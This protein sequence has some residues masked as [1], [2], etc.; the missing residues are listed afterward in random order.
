MPHR[1]G[2][3]SENRNPAHWHW[4]QSSSAPDHGSGRWSCVKS[5][6]AI[7]D[8]TVSSCA[9]NATEVGKTEPGIVLQPITQRPIESAVGEPD[10]GDRHR[11]L[12]WE[13]QGGK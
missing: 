9:S 2:S 6:L 11:R 12:I 10:Q 5:G 4:R 1:A 13:K 8:R 7:G 3:E